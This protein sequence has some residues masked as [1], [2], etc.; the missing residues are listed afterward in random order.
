MTE[1]NAESTEEAAT[2][3]RV[4]RTCADN[5]MAEPGATDYIDTRESEVDPDR[6][7]V[8]QGLVFECIG[9]STA[10]A[11]ALIT[12]WGRWQ[13]RQPVTEPPSSDRSFF[14]LSGFDELEL[15]RPTWRS[16]QEL[17][18]TAECLA[19]WRALTADYLARDGRNEA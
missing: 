5:E 1:E 17:L 6:G 16:R 3:Y 9:P 13:F 4:M 8:T 2:L 18:P 15:P 14:G 7:Q 12:P 19:V 11:I 10:T